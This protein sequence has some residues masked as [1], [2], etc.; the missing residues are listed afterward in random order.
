[1]RYEIILSPEAHEDYQRLKAHHRAE[2]RDGLE[3]YL[4]HEPAR[5]S[6]SRIKRLRGLARPQFRLRIGDLRVFYDVSESTVEVLAI[7]SKA[8][9]ES[10]L[11]QRGGVDEEGTADGSEE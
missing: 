5:T 8:D 1:M 3:R 4:R 10:W 9:A 11:E 6:R 7:V 2:V